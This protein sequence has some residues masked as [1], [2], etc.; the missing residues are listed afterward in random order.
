REVDARTDIYGLAATLYFAL[1]GVAPYQSHGALTTLGKKL[2]N[3]LV[4]PRQLVPSLGTC[5]DAAIRRALD[6]DPE[7]RP[8]SC[9]EFAAQLTGDGTA[10]ARDE[11]HSPD[12]AERRRSR[13]FPS[14]RQAV[15]RLVQGGRHSYN[16]LVEDVSLTGI[17]LKFDR[18]FEPATVL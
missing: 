15:C 9:A 18:R 17:R 13:R 2:N 12:P 4:S 7:C 10:P 16:A 5:V 11:H 8:A 3:E 1:T 6:A 14:V